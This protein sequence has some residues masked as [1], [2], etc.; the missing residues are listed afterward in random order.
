[1]LS[2]HRTLWGSIRCDQIKLRTYFSQ[3]LHKT[4]GFKKQRVSSLQEK[5]CFLLIIMI[6]Q[7][8]LVPNILIFKVFLWNWK[9]LQYKFLFKKNKF[10]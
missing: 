8:N 3:G 9:V 1:M 6:F 4:V 10:L 5:S 2:L 7:R